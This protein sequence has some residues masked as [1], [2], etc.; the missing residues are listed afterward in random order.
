VQ[1]SERMFTINGAASCVDVQGGADDPTVLLVGSSMLSWPS[2][3]CERLVAGG[4]RVIRYDVRDTGRSESYPLGE[5]GYSLA[6]LVDDAV[7]VLD[8][9]ATERAHVAGMSTGGWIAQLLALDYPER[10]ATLTL[11]ASR[12]NTPGPVDEDLPGHH[13]AVMEAIRNTPAPDWSDER[14][15]VDRL[16]LRARTLAGAGAFDETSARA[17]A[18]AEVART[19]DVRCAMTNLGFA[20]HGPRWR[21]RLGEIT[22]PTLVLHGEDDP[23]FPIGNGE[24]LAAE[25]PDARLVRLGDVGHR[26]PAHAIPAIADELL[27]HTAD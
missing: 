23:F 21:E 11:V 25:I 2:E 13:D 7:G 22:A 10:V 26:L 12:P 1:A 8:A 3:L 16:V 4:R 24:A 15:V 9:T 19:T 27:A 18:E 20:D 6:D 17:H 5:P 14:A